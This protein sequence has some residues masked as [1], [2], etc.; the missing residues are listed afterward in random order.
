MSLPTNNLK[1]V[2][3]RLKK[4]KYGKSCSYFTLIQKYNCVIYLL[5]II[6]LGNCLHRMITHSLCR[7]AERG[8]GGTMTP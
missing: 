5:I 4:L 2:L 3:R 1:G 6:S 7:V 8:A